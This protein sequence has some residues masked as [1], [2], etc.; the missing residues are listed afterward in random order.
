M[1]MTEIDFSRDI[2]PD[3]RRFTLDADA[4]K[5]TQVN[6]PHW[7]KKVTIRPEGKKC[8]IAFVEGTGDDIH[9]DYIKLSADTPSEFTFWDGYKA[10]NGITKIYVANVPAVTGATGVSVMV[11][12]SQ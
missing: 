9:A 7:A 12:G 8:R 1:A 2:C 6:I 11:E 5:A 3:I 10:S 4:D